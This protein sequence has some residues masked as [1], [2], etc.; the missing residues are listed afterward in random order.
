MLSKENTDHIKQ[1]LREHL[2]G[3]NYDI[4]SV[5]DL[6]LKNYELFDKHS[7]LKIPP[8][9]LD[10]HYNFYPRLLGYAKP[11]GTGI[12]DVGTGES[13]PFLVAQNTDRFSPPRI[14]LDPYEARVPAGWEAFKMSGTDI[15]EKFGA[16][17]FDFVQCM[18]VLEHVTQEDS[19]T[20]AKQMLQVARKTAILM[21]APV[22]VHIVPSTQAFLDRNNFMDYKGQPNIESLME[23]GYKVDLITGYGWGDT[24][25]CRV[26]ATWDIA[27]DGAKILHV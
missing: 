26:V 15:L 12:L 9:F 27:R 17:S 5:I 6:E 1:Y 19:Y 2:K 18:E 25:G 11:T 7:D 24:I 16:D 23:L 22:V 13:G 8:D 21:S 3:H 14:G 20:I 10:S 4:E